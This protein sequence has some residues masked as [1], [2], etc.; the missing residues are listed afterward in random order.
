MEDVD[1]TDSFITAAPDSTAETGVVP[2]PKGDSPTVASATFELLSEHPYR[3]RSSDV[4]FTVW[5]DRQEVPEE[6]REEAR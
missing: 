4:I 3:Y 1:Y 6:Q 5:A 2:S